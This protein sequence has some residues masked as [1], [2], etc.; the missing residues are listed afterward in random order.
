[1]V[2][3]SFSKASVNHFASKLFE[4]RSCDFADEQLIIDQQGLRGQW[5]LPRQHLAIMG[6]L[7]V[8]PLVFPHGSAL[9]S[10]RRLVSCWMA[11][12]ARRVTPAWNSSG[13]SRT[14]SV[15]PAMAI[16]HSIYRYPVKG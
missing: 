3:G 9:S 1:M 7:V 5:Q 12:R 2:A 6:F 15:A 4:H 16:I 14:T 10:H 13:E 8:P 11:G